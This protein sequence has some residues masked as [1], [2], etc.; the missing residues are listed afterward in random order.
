MIGLRYRGRRVALAGGL[1]LLLLVLPAGSAGAQHGARNGEWPHYAGDQ[2]S[3][4]YSPLDQIDRHNFSQ[5]EIAWRWESAD[6]ALEEATDMRPG[7]YRSSPLVVGGVLY[8]PTGMSQVAALDPGTGETKW[9]FDPRDWERDDIRKVGLV[10]VRGLEYWTDGTEE[11]I[12]LATRA[13]RLISIDAR[14]GEL[15]REF[16]VDGIVDLDESLPPGRINRN[17]SHSAPVIVV[18][19]TIVVGS[20]INDFP[21]RDNSPPGHIRGYDI[22]SGRLNWIFYS[23]PQAGQPYNETWEDGSWETVGN[24][25]VWSMMSADPELGYVYLPFGTPTN[26]WYGGHRKGHNLYAESI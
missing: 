19:D 3:T 2:G 16:G 4:R 15:D 20:A 8:T 21:L 23:I 6:A 11:R 22:R 7:P 25:N 10:Q 18:A 24:T 26:D 5:L 9:V 13:R 12:V 14:T 1:P 17:I